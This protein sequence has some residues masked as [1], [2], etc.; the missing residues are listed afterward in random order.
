M[1]KA[2]RRDSMGSLDLSYSDDNSVQTSEPIEDVGLNDVLPMV[3][4]WEKIK[5]MPEYAET[6]GEHIF[7]K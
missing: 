3:E 5:A 4:S 1:V 6:M 2:E 7:R